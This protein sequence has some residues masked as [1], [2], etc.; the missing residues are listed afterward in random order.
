MLLITLRKLGKY[1]AVNG[2]LG[3]G[4][5]FGLGRFGGALVEPLR[6]A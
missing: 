4:G 5:F 3:S 2:D 1:K 6:V